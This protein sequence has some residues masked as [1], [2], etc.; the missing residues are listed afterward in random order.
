MNKISKSNYSLFKPAQISTADAELSST[1]A[2]SRV[3]LVR[4]IDGQSLSII[5][6]PQYLLPTP[7][8]PLTLTGTLAGARWNIIVDQ[9]DVITLA[10]VIEPMLH[11]RDFRPEN[12]G[13]TAKSLMLYFLTP[14]LDNSIM[15]S[16]DV[17]EGVENEKPS[18][19][20][21]G[22]IIRLGQ[23]KFALRA[24]GG[25]RFNLLMNDFL[26]IFD[27]K[28]QPLAAKISVKMCFQM[29]SYNL[30]RAELKTL[31]AGDVIIPPDGLGCLAIIGKY[32]FAECEMDGRDI[33]IAQ[34]LKYRYSHDM[35][36]EMQRSETDALLD[37]EDFNTVNN[38]D[39]VPV[40]LHFEAGK[41]VIT[42]GELEKIGQGHVFVNIGHPAGN[43]D[44]MAGGRRIGRAELVSVD[45]ATGFRLIEFV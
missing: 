4:N 45:G 22:F 18:H 40:T 10:Q 14:F 16:L 33:R 36:H 39:Q 32:A 13:T 26:S 20:M 12:I 25:P 21:W 23:Y 8:K 38:L 2:M 3:P 5:P 41:T 30:T 24:F 1:L 43:I 31:Q 44:I 37:E 11:D 42:L 29:A 6:S 27:Q 34:L 28:K 19:S 7:G 17:M 15:G 35:E 9:T